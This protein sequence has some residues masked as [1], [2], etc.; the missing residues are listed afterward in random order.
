MPGTMLGSG[1]TIVRNTVSILKVFK[2][3]HMQE[4]GYQIPTLPPSSDII[5]ETQ[6]DPKQ[7]R[8]TYPDLW[9][10]GRLP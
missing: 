4:A 1:D 9:G 7:R 5:R 6:G 3:W 8:V 2:L 10:Q